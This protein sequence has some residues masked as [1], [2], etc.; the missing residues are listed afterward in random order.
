MNNQWRLIHHSGGG[1][2]VASDIVHLCPLSD[3]QV[4]QE[5]TRDGDDFVCQD[6][7]N[8]AKIDYSMFYG[9]SVP[10]T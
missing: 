2:I 8:R 9:K 6:C 7:G 3:D 1:E 4:R 5:I 10:T